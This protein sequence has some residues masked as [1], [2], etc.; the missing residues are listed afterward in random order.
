MGGT[1][2]RGVEERTLDETP[3][4]AFDAAV[5]VVLEEMEMGIFELLILGR[6]RG[7]G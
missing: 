3:P 5:V 6:S 4:P 7:D 2:L 1:L